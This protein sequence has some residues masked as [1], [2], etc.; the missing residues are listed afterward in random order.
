LSGV[1]ITFRAGRA[2]V[3]LNSATIFVTSIGA[4]LIIAGILALLAPSDYLRYRA[5]HAVR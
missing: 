1:F 3:P 5:R 2:G 4:A